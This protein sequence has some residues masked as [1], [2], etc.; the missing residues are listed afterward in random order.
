[1]AGLNL[2]GLLQTIGVLPH[3]P[4][5]PATSTGSLAPTTSAPAPELIP[6]HQAPVDPNKGFGGPDILVSGGRPKTLAPEDDPAPVSLGNRSQI[7]EIQQAASNAPQHEGM[8]HTKGTLRNILGV[9][10]DAFLVQS[11]NKAVY[12][13]QRQREKESDAIAGFTQ[14]P[15]AA[16]ERLGGVNADA[17]Q[18]LYKNAQTAQLTAQAKQAAFEQAKAERYTKGSEIFGRFMG[19]T[20]AQSYEQTKPLLAKIKATYGLGDEFTVPDNYDPDTAHT[21]Q[22]GGMPATNQVRDA[23][24]QEAE[25]G[26]NDRADASIEAANSRNALNEAGR[27]KRDH[28]PAARTAPPRGISA[29]DADVAQAVLNGTANPAQQKYYNDRLVHKKQSALERITGGVSAAP[30]AA[31]PKFKEGKVVYQFGHKFVVKNGVPTI[32]Q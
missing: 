28:P 19:S 17:G 1:M 21:Y 20:N 29:V 11:G 26:R 13:S 32:S 14:N 9:L 30:V 6:G 25:Q 16:A 4:D 3:T 7:E 23:R 8:F 27:M 18:E 12:A 31:A 10:G 24:T 5:A 2:L 15:M 22:Y